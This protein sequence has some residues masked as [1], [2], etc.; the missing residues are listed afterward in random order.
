MPDG[1]MEGIPL[2]EIRVHPFTTLF[3]LA[4]IVRTGK[5]RQHKERRLIRL[6]HIHEIADVSRHLFF[7]IKRKADDISRMNDYARV[8]PFV[9]DLPVLFDTILA[10]PFGLEVLRVDAFHPDKNLSAAGLPS[11]PTEIFRLAR[12]VY[13]DHKRDFDSLIP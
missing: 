6:D 5:R 12:E 10:F 9:D 7:G 2:V 8:V 1:G 13:L 11:K 4:V 3:H